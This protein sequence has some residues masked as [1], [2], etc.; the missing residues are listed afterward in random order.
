[1]PQADVLSFITLLGGIEAETP[2]ILNY[3]T[4][5]AKDLGHQGIFTEWQLVPTV[6]GQGIYPLD[7]GVIEV[8]GVFFDDEFLSMAQLKELEARNPNWRDAIGHPICYT[9]EQ[10][11]K[12][13]I[14][15]YPAPEAGSDP[16]IFIH[17]A[18]F[19][20]DYPRGTAAVIVSTVRTDYPTWIDLPYAL[21][22][23]ALEFERDSDHR[24]KNFADVCTTLGGLMMAMVTAE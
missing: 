10:Q 20:L 14:Q 19:G 3:Y 8:L 11:D 1:M 7:P 17:G 22:V 23:M 4:D 15:L 9:E 2:Q 5:I 6:A 24:N 13:T 18:P 16:Q 21:A 12:N